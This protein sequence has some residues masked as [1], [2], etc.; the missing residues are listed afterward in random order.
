ME[1]KKKVNVLAIIL[2]IL[3]LC[4]LGYI[5]YD[6]L[7][8]KK[9]AEKC[10]VEVETKEEEKEETAESANVSTIEYNKDGYYVRDLMSK[11]YSRTTDNSEN[12]L[13]VKERTTVDDLSEKYVNY[14]IINRVLSSNSFAK[15]E[16]EEE[17]ELMFG[18]K[19]TRSDVMNSLCGISYNL[20]GDA[21]IRSDVDGGCGGIGLRY[22]DKIT[23][24]E[25]DSMHIYVYQ[26]KGFQCGD[27]ICKEVKQSSDGYEAYEEIGA[28]DLSVSEELITEQY[29]E[30]LHEYKFTFTYD[31]TNNIHY[32]ESI[33]RVS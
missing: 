24:V 2:F 19:I 10:R 6:K 4:S 25:S 21:Y 22:F 29:L 15:S 11:I 12:G 5:G 7:I 16:F 20:N 18:K 30:Q 1:E 32:F 9:G 13:Y 3:L 26:K 28:V 33:E 14:L 17:S 27:K 31:S 8:A 23:K